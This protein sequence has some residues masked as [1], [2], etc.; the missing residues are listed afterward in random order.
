MKTALV[1]GAGGGIGSPVVRALA[2]RGW[3]VV[4]L[5]HG[6]PASELPL[7]GW[8]SSDVDS[9]SL[10]AV[11]AEAKPEAI[12]HLAGGSSVRNSVANPDSDYERTVLGTRRLLEW[13]GKRAPDA[14]LVLAS[15]AAVYGTATQ[16]PIPENAALRPVSPYGV[17]KLV[18]EQMA[19]ESGLR[20]VCLRLF[21]VYGSELRKQLVWE[22][23]SRLAQGDRHLRLGGTGEETRDWLHISDAAAML[24]D[25]LAFVRP[26]A[27]VLNGCTGLGTPV[28][29]VAR[30]VIAGFGVDVELSFSGEA[31]LGDPA[32]LVGDPR[33]AA[34]AG[35]T[36]RILAIEGLAETARKAR[37]AL[38]VIPGCGT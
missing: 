21:S 12:I 3:R 34:A 1:T 26:G 36:A 30:A 17:H 23:I 35:I 37:K 11:T 32:H 28:S 4:G 15:S 27:P 10:D 31:R 25:A 20:T 9:H 24:V 18:M 38:G 14:A 33:N 16:N 22:L 6:T 7:S 8:L 19:R 2:D 13:M 5:G 29:K